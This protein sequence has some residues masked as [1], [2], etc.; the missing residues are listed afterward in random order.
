[1]KKLLFLIGTRPEVIKIAPL[2]R[3]CRQKKSFDTHLC[4]SGQHSTLLTDALTDAALT[5]D[6]RFSLEGTL[7]QK[8]ACCL[9]CFEDI[10]KKE[11]PDAVAVHGDTLTAFSGAVAAFYHRIPVFHVEAGLR[12][13]SVYAPFPE[14]FYRRSIDSLSTLCF[15]PTE[16]AAKRL[17]REGKP[18]TA[19]HIVGNTVLDTLS[20]DLSHSFS[21]P[22]IKK[23]KK[24][25]LM[26]LHR[27]E[28]QGE[29]AR[30]ICEGVKQALTARE[31][32]YLLFPV[33]PSPHV[34]ETVFSV[35]DGAE[36]ITLLPPL[37]RRTFRNLLATATLV[38]TD[39]G[40]V[41]EEATA[42]GIPTLLLREVTERT[43]G[44]TA[45]VLY[46]VGIRSANI[47]TAVTDFLDHPRKRH[48]STV[49]GTGNASEQIADL[50]EKFF[51][52]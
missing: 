9:T 2:I 10:L 11:A 43:E 20:S 19:V 39:S 15:A 34:R 30:G 22:F 5:P 37:D 48:P 7:S 18:S 36:N 21:S 29:D 46:P 14:E 52:K 51:L 27:R 44:V 45:G 35:L 25:I 40:G 16:H 6:T 42:L 24:L 8:T 4:T 12:A 33:H 3:A 31:D 41:S 32:A 1:M 13:P 23:G 50:I 38:L 17:Y 49:F 47:L 26:T 28:T